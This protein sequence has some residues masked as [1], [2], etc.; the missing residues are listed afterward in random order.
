[1][2]NATRIIG[3]AKLHQKLKR[4]PDLAKAQIRRAMEL[5][6]DEIVA[7][8]KSLAPDGDT[9]RLKDSIGWTWGKAPRGSLTL[10]KVAESNLGG[11]LTI[12]IY[13]GNDEAFYARWV[14]FGTR[15]HAVGQGS[16][17]SVGKGGKQSGAMHPGSAARPFFYPSYR[18]NKKRTVSRIR[19]AVNNAAKEAAAGSS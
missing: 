9:G 18:A 5:G 4:M 3:L 7:M 12:T 15:P 14:E 10:G 2:A 11:E 17:I 13:A 8:A 1:M 16:D 6:A 19:R